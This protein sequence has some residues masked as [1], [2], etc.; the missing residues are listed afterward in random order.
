[1]KVL[2][3]R[4]ALACLLERAN[5]LA[6]GF[7]DIH[8]TAAQADTVFQAKTL[9]QYITATVRAFPGMKRLPLDA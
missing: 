7:A 5:T 1:M 8:I 9:P 4:A 6:R 3:S 2:G